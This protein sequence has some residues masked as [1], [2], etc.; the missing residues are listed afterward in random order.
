LKLLLILALPLLCS[1]DSH[2]ERW[3][4]WVELG[5]HR[6]LLAEAEELFKAPE[7]NPELLA[8]AAR[9]AHASGMRQHAVAWLARGQGAPIELERARQQLEEDRLEEALALLLV[10]GEPPTPL[11]PNRADGWMLSARALTRAGELER[12]RPLLETMIARFPHD[13]EAPAAL[14]LLSQAAIASGDLKSARSLRVRANSS[15]RWR[16]FFDARRRQSIEHPEDPLPRFGVAALWM[17]V[18]EA[19]RARDVLDKLLASASDFARG[20]AL[21]GDAS[22]ALGELDESLS[23]W[24]RALEIDESLHAARLNRAIL[25]GTRSLWPEARADLE[26][27]VA[28]EEAKTEPLIRAH[29]ELARALEALGDKEGAASARAKYELLKSQDAPK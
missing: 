15:A 24:S 10:P 14:H 11:H 5:L 25:L 8:L 6:P 3:E 2:E 26:L 1:N 21:R 4:E 20:H 23:S 17:E 29:L 16:A 22:R 19:Q 7:V 12:A 9:A 27:L 28:Q 18:N 13:D